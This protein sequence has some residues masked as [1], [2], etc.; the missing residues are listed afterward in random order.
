MSKIF[1]FAILNGDNIENIYLFVGNRNVNSNDNLGPDG[2]N[3][4][5]W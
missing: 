2:E 5:S 1:K 3:I 4:L